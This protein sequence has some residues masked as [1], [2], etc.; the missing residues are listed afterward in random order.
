MDCDEGECCVFG[1][2]HSGSNPF[3]KREDVVPVSETA[4][5]DFCILVFTV[6]LIIGQ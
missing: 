6:L 3:G 5:Q 4:M 2:V 1:G